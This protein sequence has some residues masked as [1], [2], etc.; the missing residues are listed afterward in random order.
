M[1]CDIDDLDFVNEWTECD[2][3]EVNLVPHGKRC[4]TYSSSLDLSYVA[5]CVDG[6]WVTEET[7]LGMKSFI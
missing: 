7:S 3:T 4:V 2:E 6:V 1:A 5:R